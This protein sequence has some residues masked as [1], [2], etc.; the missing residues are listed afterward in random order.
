M[1]DR[2]FPIRYD[3]S[4]PV[5][6]QDRSLPVNNARKNKKYTNCQFVKGGWTVIIEQDR[7]VD[8]AA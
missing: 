3:S 7:S 8:R 6:A 4:F 1:Y 2:S 5:C